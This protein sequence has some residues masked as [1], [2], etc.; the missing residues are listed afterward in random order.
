MR[1]MLRPEALTPQTRGLLP[2]MRACRA[3]SSRLMLAPDRVNA[4][5]AIFR[6]RARLRCASARGLR[7]TGFGR[8][9][10][11]RKSLAIGDNLRLYFFYGD[12]LRFILP[13]GCSSMSYTQNV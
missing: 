9:E 2:P 13:H 10:A 1:A 12:T 8:F 5:F 3:T 7:G 6:M 4:S 11:I